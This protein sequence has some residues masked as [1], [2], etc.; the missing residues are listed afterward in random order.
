LQ[1]KHYFWAI[2]G[3]LLMARIGLIWTAVKVDY[4]NF[5]TGG[6]RTIQNTRTQSE[7]LPYLWN[8]ITNIEEQDLQNAT[9]D[10]IDRIGYINY[11]SL[12][13][14]HV[15]RV[16]PHQDGDIWKNAILHV[17]M[18][19]AIFPN[20]PII[21]DS[22]HT[23]KYTGRYFSGY[24]VASFSLGYTADAYVDFGKFLMF[25][26][27]FLLGLFMGKCFQFFLLRSKNMVWGI[28]FTAPFFF[29]TNVYGM[30][31]VKVVG[32]LLAYVIF[33]GITRNQIIK[34]V[35]PLMRENDKP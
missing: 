31:T 34:Y 2:F 16:V 7:S 14:N 24:G 25:I 8:L 12:A 13:I 33:I 9:D 5:L 4:R 10:L 18:P 28:I 27:I 20:K 29:F 1:A 19:R 23:S 26:P 21:D 11:F 15:P 32:L 17:F 30:N 6:A 22:E 35:D 3:I